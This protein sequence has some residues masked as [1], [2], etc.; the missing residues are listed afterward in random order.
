[1]PLRAFRF[2]FFPGVPPLPQTMCCKTRQVRPCSREDV[3]DRESHDFDVGL[4]DLFA[5][6]Q[7]DLG[8]LSTS[9]E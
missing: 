4:R 1:M 8:S 9:K 6:S 7:L 5:K 3:W 2:R